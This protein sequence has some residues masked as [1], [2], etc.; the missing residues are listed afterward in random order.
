[1]K[2]KMK[3]KVLLLAVASVM[4]SVLSTQGREFHSTQHSCCCVLLTTQLIHNT[5]ISVFL[6]LLAHDTLQTLT[7]LMYWNNGEF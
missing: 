4:S 6:V 7:C 3:M 5:V 1:M 2:M